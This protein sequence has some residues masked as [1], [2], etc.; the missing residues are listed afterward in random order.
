MK[1]DLEALLSLYD[2][3]YPEELIAT[4][5]SSPRDAARLL[6]YS[7]A[8]GEIKES[9]FSRLP[10]FLPPR[11]LLIFNET[12]VLPA[13]LV[14][15]KRSGGRA[16]ALVVGLEEGLVKVM[17]DRKLSP[18]DE[19]LIAGKVFKVKGQEEKYFFLIPP[20]EFFDSTGI[21]LPA[22]YAFLEREGD[23]PLPPYIKHSPLS[24]GELLEEYQTVFARN[25]GSVAAPTAALHFTDRLIEKLKSAGHEVQFITLHVGLGTFAPLTEENISLGRLHKEYYEISPDVSA[26]ISRAKDEER[27]IIAVGTT[28][29]RALEA[30]AGEDGNLKRLSGETDLFISEGYCFKI[31]NGLITNFHVPRSSL[32]MLVAGLVGREKLLELYRFAISRKFKLFSFGDGMLVY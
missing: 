2:Y 4:T 20:E 28:A 13:R 10:E 26:A 14:L 16:K 8:S 30:A 22:F 6:T 12:K 17:A 7:K 15:S 25:R 32:M 23:V 31:V 24:R 21:S 3:S 18:G 1:N 29:T 9:D 11:S 5:P 19:L 27:P